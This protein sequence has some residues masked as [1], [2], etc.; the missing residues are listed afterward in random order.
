MSDR[1]RRLRTD[2]ARSSAGRILVRGHDLNRLLGNVDLGSMAYLELFGRLPDR[3]TARMWNALLVALVEHGITPSTLAARFTY[4]GAP[5]SLQGAVAAGLAGVGSRFAGAMEDV[6]RMLQDTMAAG[7][8][9]TERELARAAVA[10]LRADRRAVPG[11][12]HPLHRSADP[13]T[14]RLFRI[15][16]ETRTAGRGVALMRAIHAEVAREGRPLPLNAAG[17]VGAVATDLGVP[18][19]LCRG[20]AVAARAIGLVAHLNEERER[21]IA[22]EIWQRVE[23][24]LRVTAR[25]PASRSGRSSQRS[26]STGP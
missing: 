6:A 21:P 14:G 24:E 10:P 23:D 5:E 15:A 9:R 17:A 22:F 3:R 11:L 1:V 12:G 25:R 18:W 8:G 26:R 16:R 13:R 19:D 20:L 7:A 4:L 2:I